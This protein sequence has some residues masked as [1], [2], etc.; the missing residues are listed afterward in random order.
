MEYQ[1]SLFTF[2]DETQ[3]RLRDPTTEKAMNCV[4]EDSLKRAQTKKLFEVQYHLY[5]S[6]VNKFKVYIEFFWWNIFMVHS[7]YTFNIPLIKYS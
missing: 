3:Y 1:C 6:S 2:T 5:Y 7:K 4:L